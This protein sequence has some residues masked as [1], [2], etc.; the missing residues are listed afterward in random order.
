MKKLSILFLFIAFGLTACGVDQKSVDG[1]LDNLGNP[2]ALIGACQN[3]LE[4]ARDGDEGDA[5][6]ADVERAVDACESLM[7]GGIG[8][9]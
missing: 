1:V 3:L 6:P 9:Y 8:I 2:R 7:I 5:D 4:D